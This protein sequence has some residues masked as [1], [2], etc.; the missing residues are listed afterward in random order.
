MSHELSCHI[1]P[2]FSLFF[3]K[4]TITNQAVGPAV[5][6]IQ[7][8][9]IAPFYKM[10]GNQLKRNFSGWEAWVISS[11]LEAMKFV[12]LRPDKKYKLFNGP[13][14]VQLAKYTLFDG[15]L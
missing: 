4:F 7:F 14:E 11:N 5:G 9:N 13:L 2:G 15:D 12:G 1:C 3:W 10:I 8:K 6:N